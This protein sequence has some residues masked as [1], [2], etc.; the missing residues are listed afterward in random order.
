MPLLEVD[1]AQ[2]LRLLWLTPQA[3]D[4]PMLHPVTIF[5]V[6]KGIPQL[7]PFLTTE[8]LDLL[9]TKSFTNLQQCRRGID[10]L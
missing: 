9:L 1:H 7:M 6:V 2:G 8:A 10:L 5:G 4:R 3:L